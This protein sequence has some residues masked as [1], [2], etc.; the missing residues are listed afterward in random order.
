MNDSSGYGNFL[1]GDGDR[2]RPVCIRESLVTKNTGRRV[3]SLVV[4]NAVA[5]TRGVHIKLL[6]L[7]ERRKK[8]L[9]GRGVFGR[10]G[11]PAVS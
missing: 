8:H 9:N 7:D 2:L 5:D 3:L 11:A 1:H 6:A 4:E 10:A